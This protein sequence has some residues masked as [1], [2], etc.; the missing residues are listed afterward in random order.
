MSDDLERILG[1]LEVDWAPAGPSSYAVTLPGTHK[2]STTCLL[3]VEDHALRIEAF[4]IRHPDENVAG[5]HADLLRRNAR[6]YAVAFTVDGHG[7]IWLMGRV[8][9]SAITAEELDR[10][11]G[12]VLT[13]A[14]ESFDPL[15]E[16]GFAESIRREWRWRLSRGE[17]TRNLAAFEHLR[18]G[19]E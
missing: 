10:I 3:H 11:L 2:L 4:V 6:M 15:L 7:D 8:P 16:L 12:S 19:G 18:P 9:L 14:D 17:S 5:V 13:Y 1:E